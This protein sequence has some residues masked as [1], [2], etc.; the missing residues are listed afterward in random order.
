MSELLRRTLGEGIAIET[1]LSGGLWRTSADPSE[2]ENAILNLCV[3]ARDAMEGAGRLTIET[4]NAELDQGYAETHPEVVPGAYVVICVTDTGPGM[5][6]EVIDRAFE[7]FFTT[8]GAGK[9]T[10]LG[11]SQVY[12]FV[13]Q[14]GGHVGI[15]SEMGVGTTV[16]IYLPRYLGEGASARP[17][18]LQGGTPRAQ[19]GEVILVVEDEDRVR[20]VSAES[21]RELGYTVL[22]APRAEIALQLL[23]ERP[24]ITLLLTDIVMPEVD[25][26]Q[27]A[28]R[29]LV[30]RPDLPIVFMTG[31]T[32]N[33]IIHNGVVDAG[34]NLL[35]KPFT[36]EQLARKLRAVLDE[37]AAQRAGHATAG[38]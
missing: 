8:K 4:A 5:P 28:D 3:N 15:Y 25:G 31:Y 37:C 18:E 6:P 21:L 32:R 38:N 20:R 13:R 22:E 7:P 26:R 2:L 36:M 33:A 17:A 10:G 29:A 30:L 1:V 23:G 11:L 34:I 9:G 35:P 24:E 16:K 14:S 19:P 27:L 12:G